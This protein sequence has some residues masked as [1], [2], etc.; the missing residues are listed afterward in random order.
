MFRGGSPSLLR[1]GLNSLSVVFLNHAAG[2]FGDEVIAASAIVGRLVIIAGAALLGLG[3]GFQP[4]CGFNYG[5]KQYGRVKKAF[6]FT[7]KLTTA[8]LTIVAALGFIFAPRIIAVFRKDDLTVIDVGT[9]SLRL[10]CFT[11][12]LMGWI[13]INNMMLQTIGKAVPASILA[14]ARQGIFLIPLLFILPP[15]LGI[16][17]IQIATPLSDLLTFALAI[18]MGLHTLREMKEGKERSA[19]HRADAFVSEQFD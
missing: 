12:P 18:P 19:N 7:M 9:L 11:I 13:V 15:A 1:Q 8:L 2:A 16:L 4:V 5:A 14:A 17:G 10:Q 3:Q 6:W